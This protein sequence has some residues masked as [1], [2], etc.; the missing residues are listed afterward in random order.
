MTH[1]MM[2]RA[3]AQTVIEM[4]DVY[5]ERVEIAG[6]VRRGKTDVKDV[7]IVLIPRAGWLEHLDVLVEAGVIAK[8]PYGANGQHR[9][10]TKYRG[11]VYDGVRIELFAADADNWGYILW[12]RT[13]PGDA[14]EYVMK[15]LKA[16]GSSL[17][18]RGGYWWRGDERMATPDEDSVFALLGIEPIPPA[19][20]S[21]IVYRGAFGA[22]QRRQIAALAGS[23]YSM[24]PQHHAQREEYESSPPTEW[25]HRLLPEWID[26]VERQIEQLY[27]DET[28]G[29]R[30]RVAGLRR[31]AAA[32][33]E[34]YA[35]GLE[36]GL[37]DVDSTVLQSGLQ[38]S[39]SCES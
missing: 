7:E 18:A 1:I 26:D 9:W 2:A 32:Y 10:G 22:A 25:K 33:R 14:N 17:S 39:E 37:P 6:S 23:R 27:L 15:Q 35:E 11:L 13:G 4:I 28:F 16:Q 3:A 24:L 8:A 29:N 21:V 30:I 19:S 34:R 20:R 36:H 31:L 12:L 5:C 38:G